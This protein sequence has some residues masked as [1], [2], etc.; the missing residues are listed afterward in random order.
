M[1]PSPA[2]KKELPSTDEGF[3]DMWEAHPHNYQEHYDGG[4]AD[5]N[6]SS[7]ELLEEEG[8]PAWM[9]N[10]CAIRLSKMLNNM[11]GAFAITYKSAAAAGIPKKRVWRGKKQADGTRELFI[12]SASEMWTYLEKNYRSA[13]EVYPGSGKFA[14]SAAFD[15][16][17][18]GGADPIKDKIASQKGIVAFEKI[19][20]YGGTGHVD[21]FNGERLSDAAEWYPSQR[22]KIWNV[23]V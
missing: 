17:W 3:D 4:S 14:D 20:G 5:D 13:D 12:V 19:F 15:A 18:D 16:A 7:P 9:N 1:N 23:V 21:I 10:T 6:T 8:L 22:I 11:G 2:T